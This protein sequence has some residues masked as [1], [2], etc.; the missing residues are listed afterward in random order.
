ME[1]G[2][3]NN[4]IQLKHFFRN[5]FAIIAVFLMYFSLIE[6]QIMFTLGDILSI[7]VLF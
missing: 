5:K 4:R 2:K 1:C 3:Q 7:K 6:K